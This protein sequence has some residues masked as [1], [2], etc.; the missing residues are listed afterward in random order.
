MTWLKRML[1]GLGIVLA[2]V[3]AI[4][5]AIGHWV[6]GGGG[7]NVRRMSMTVGDRT[8]TVAGQFK[9]M[10]QETLAEGMKIT[11]DNHVIT[12]TPGEL[13]IDS[14]PQAVDP[15]QDVEIWI[16]EKGGV[17]V[18]AVSSDAGSAGK[19]PE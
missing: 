12:A 6:P 18:K 15:G 16:N 7:P 8:I 10:T 5:V 13:T 3:I 9:T 11:V 19:A 2:L 4:V 1:I 14:K 17:E